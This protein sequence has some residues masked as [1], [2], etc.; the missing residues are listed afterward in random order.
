[1]LS[2]IFLGG[3]P[4]NGVKFRA[5]G[6]MHHARWLAKAIYCLKIYMFRKQFLISDHDVKALREI[7]IFLVLFYLEAWFVATDP[8][9]APNFDLKLFLNLLIFKNIYPKIGE[10]ALVKLSG[11]LW[12]LHEQLAILALFDPTVSRQQKIKMAA[13]IKNEKSQMTSEGKRLTVKKN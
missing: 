1:M 12:Y 2:Y 8:I 3:I 10:A 4:K 11:H 13:A 5:P 9:K 7:C 6:A